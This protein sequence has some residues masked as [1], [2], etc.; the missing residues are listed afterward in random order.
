MFRAWAGGGVS[1]SFLSLLGV[2]AI[3]SRRPSWSGGVAFLSIVTRGLFCFLEFEL[4]GGVLI[5]VLS[6]ESLWRLYTQEG[7]VSVR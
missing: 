6:H 4:V 3:I 2:E 1:A 5:L 7:L